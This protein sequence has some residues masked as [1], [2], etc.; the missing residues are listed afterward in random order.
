ME[1][2]IVSQK[3]ALKAADTPSGGSVILYRAYNKKLLTV[4]LTH[5]I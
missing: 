3:S 2:D 1:Q 4:V 5:L